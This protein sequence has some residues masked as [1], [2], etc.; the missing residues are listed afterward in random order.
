MWVLMLMTGKTR[1]W[2]R[3][4]RI[5]LGVVGVVGVVWT[6]RSRGSMLAL[7]LAL[8]LLSGPSCRLGHCSHCYGHSWS[9]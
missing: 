1:K 2:S 8:A 9:G 5:L 4:R 6:P 7:P 3:T